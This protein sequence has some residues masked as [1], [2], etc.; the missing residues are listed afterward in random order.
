M[1]LIWVANYI[2]SSQ[3]VW[4]TATERPL[5]NFRGH[6]GRL[7]CAVWTS[8]IHSDNQKSSGIIYT[9]ADDYTVHGWYAEDQEHT[10]P[11][12]GEL[13]VNTANISCNLSS[14]LKFWLAPPPPPIF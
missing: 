9:G 11:V 6:H 14:R 10:E 3:Q 1:I 4:N 13:L 2:L 8:V 5:Y 7:M 12:K